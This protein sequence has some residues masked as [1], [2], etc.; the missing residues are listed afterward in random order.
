MSKLVV[1]G[2]KKLSGKVR[3]AGNK[4]STFGIFA[5]SLLASTPSTFTNVPDI[6]DVAISCQILEKL[7]C[8]I[9]RPKQGVLTLDPAG[10]SS[11][12]P[13]PVLAGRVRGAIVFSA[14][15]Y[16]RFGKVILPRPG[17]DQIGERLIGTHMK[18]FES[19]GAK[20]QEDCNNRLISISYN[21]SP[22]FSVF[23][24]EASVTATEIAIL[25]AASYPEETVIE[26]AAC[27]PHIVDLCECL[28]TMGVKIEGAGTNTVRVKGKKRLYGVEHRIRPDHIEVGT[29]AI[30]SA[31]TG[32]N[33][34]IED[35]IFQDLRMILIYLSQMGVEYTFG[36]NTLF[37]KPSKLVASRRKFQT[38]PHPGFPTDLMSPFIV[39]ATQSIGSVLCHDWMYEWR[40][41]FVDYLR[42]MGA[43]ILIA[44]P[45]RVIVNGPSRLHGEI[46]PSTDIR[47]GCSLVLAGL[48]AYGQ[49]VVENAEIIDRGYERF[50]QRLSLL[51]AN[52]KR[53]ED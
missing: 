9:T 16:A 46:V 6:R 37:V 53:V 38:R 25:L 30:A 52:I 47:A 1:E 22:S 3:V 34:A 51:G 7:G 33:I 50:E 5:A 42:T 39:L 21:K 43:D 15:L 35:A 44:D 49:T 45:H 19:F 14:P 11:F 20:I 17:G 10:L 23:L 4:N 2:R 29:F 27:E 41:F 36:K 32:G 18:V 26:D 13:D 24:E 12:A 28:V 31:I 48:A 40:I 8:K